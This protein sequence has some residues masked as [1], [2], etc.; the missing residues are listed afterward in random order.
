MREGAQLEARKRI[1]DA[2]TKAKE[3]LLE[4]KEKAV[5][6]SEEIKKRGDE[7]KTGTSRDGKEIDG[8]RTVAR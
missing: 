8:K 4:A 3:I 2:E 1:A 5:K 7:K 6:N